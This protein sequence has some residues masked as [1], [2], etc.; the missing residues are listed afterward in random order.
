MEQSVSTANTKAEA[1][2]NRIMA[3]ETELFR[4][5]VS[6]AGLETDVSHVRWKLCILTITDFSLQYRKVIDDGKKLFAELST[7]LRKAQEALSIAN[8]TVERQRKAG[9]TKPIPSSQKEAQLQKEVD[10]C[11]VGTERDSRSR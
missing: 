6:R 9:D 1:F 10:K 5:R 4:A 2:K 11:M 8:L 3:L 7:E